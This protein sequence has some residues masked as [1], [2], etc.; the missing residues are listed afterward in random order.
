MNILVNPTLSGNKLDCFSL[1]TLSS[2]SVT[3]MPAYC[4]VELISIVKSFIESIPK[5]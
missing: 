3:N 5:L 4:A 1:T 2:F